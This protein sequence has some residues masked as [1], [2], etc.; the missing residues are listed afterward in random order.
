MLR[1]IDGSFHFVHY[2]CLLDALSFSVCVGLKVAAHKG[3]IYDWVAV[4]E[5][6]TA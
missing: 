5:N 6:N 4:A 1:F 3:Y 2:P